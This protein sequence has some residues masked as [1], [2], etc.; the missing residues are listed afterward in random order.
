MTKS[1]TTVEGVDASLP[2]LSPTPKHLDERISET[3]K[4]SAMSSAIVALAALASHLASASSGETSL[5]GSESD[6]IDSGVSELSPASSAFSRELQADCV[7]SSVYLGCFRDR[8]NNRAMEFQVPGKGHSAAT[9]E[10]ECS[11]RGYMYFGRECT[12]WCQLPGA[13]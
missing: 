13:T 8:K 3:M 6:A 11:S 1:L 9:C 7:A 2:F 4:S 5:R 12:W 10:A